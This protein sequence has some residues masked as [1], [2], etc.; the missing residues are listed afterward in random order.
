MDRELSVATMLGVV[1]ISLAAIIGLGFG[2]FQIIKVN[3]NTGSADANDKLGIISEKEFSDYNGTTVMG[4]YAL[5]AINNFEQRN[6]AV[7]IAT[8][9]YKDCYNKNCGLKNGSGD[10]LSGVKDAYGIKNANLTNFTRNVVRITDGSFMTSNSSGDMEGV[11][12]NYNTLL[13]S[14]TLNTLTGSA[15]K[16]ITY[17][18][19]SGRFVCT[20]GF[21]SIAGNSN[22]YA[23]NSVTK[24]LT[25]TG[26]VEYIPVAA[27]FNSYLIVD[28]GGAIVGI[29]LDQIN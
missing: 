4:Q 21:V 27:K 22:S 8:T 28:S 23:K 3:A 5:E 25:R 20:S 13:G 14:G 29:A 26:M 11:F 16:Q 10:D 19:K 24:N 15:D 9:A 12:V 18:V 2:I 1:L 17:N 6:M 7:L